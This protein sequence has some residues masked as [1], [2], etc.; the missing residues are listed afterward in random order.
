MKPK[1]RRSRERA[2]EEE[3][4]PLLQNK[5]T[6]IVQRYRV[7]CRRGPPKYE[8]MKQYEMERKRN[9][10][11]KVRKKL[12]EDPEM[13]ERVREKKRLEMRAYRKK[14]KEQEQKKRDSITELES[15]KSKAAK[16]ASKRRAESQRKAK[17]RSG[18]KEKR[19]GAAIRKKLAVLN[20][21]KWRLRVKLQKVS[22]TSS[23]DKNTQPFSSKRT[24]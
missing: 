19:E 22:S 15:N 24:E 12:L 7:K 18:E 3:Q 8:K 10:R 5:R 4:L 2:E 16:E 20:T 1:Q 14:K 21:Q 9:E 13:Q 11:A 23:E 6:E 17:A